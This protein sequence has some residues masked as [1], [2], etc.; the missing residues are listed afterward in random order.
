MSG[1]ECVASGDAPTSLG[2]EGLSSISSQ[3][4]STVRGLASISALEILAE[5]FVPPNA[6]L[7]A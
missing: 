4:N 2:G 6:E 1:V 3:K 7:S 5:R